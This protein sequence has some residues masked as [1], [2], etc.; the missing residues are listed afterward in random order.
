MAIANTDRTLSQ[1]GTAIAPKR[2]SPDQFQDRFESLVPLMAQEWTSIAPEDIEAT[3]GD[4]DLTV[5]L[6]T[7]A[8]EHTKILIHAQL[9]ELY[10][11]SLNWERQERTETGPGK[12]LTRSTDSKLEP[13]E[14]TET[15]D[16]PPSPSID[17]VLDLLERRTEKTGRTGQGGCV[18]GGEVSGQTQLR[19][20]DFNSVGD[21]LFIRTLCGRKWWRSHLNPR[22]SRRRWKPMSAVVWAYSKFS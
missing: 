9:A 14:K 8:T 22:A 21:W 1:N 15:D 11:L 20:L 2:L 19:R 4:L 6:I 10:S 17:D 5:D 13:S 18:T 3:D 12:E 16:N 7:E